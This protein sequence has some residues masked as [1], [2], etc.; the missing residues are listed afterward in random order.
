[1]Q[2]FKDFLKE[3]NSKQNDANVYNEAVPLIGPALGTAA[4]AAIPA[5]V[6]AA[7]PTV[8]RAVGTTALSSNLKNILKS[9]SGIGLDIATGAASGIASNYGLDNI[10]S[11][12]KDGEDNVSSK[13]NISEI[14]ERIEKAIETAEKALKTNLANEYK[15]FTLELSKAMTKMTSDFKFKIDKMIEGITK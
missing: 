7:T 13:E 12:R 10:F 1:M 11:S 4:R 2:N 14:E 15:N 6:R 5:V 9:L 3:K 8:A